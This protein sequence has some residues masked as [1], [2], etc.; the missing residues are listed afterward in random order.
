LKGAGRRRTLFD[1]VT[2]QGKPMMD[3]STKPAAGVTL[4]VAS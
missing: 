4:G 2:R 1:G 3:R